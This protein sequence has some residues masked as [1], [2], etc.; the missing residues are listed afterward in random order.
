MKLLR[1]TLFVLSCA[2]LGTASANNPPE[3]NKNWMR[4]LDP[5]VRVRDISIPGTHDSGAM[6][7][8][9]NFSI[10]QSMTIPQQ[11]SAGIRYLD[12]R[13][14]HINNVFAIHHGE[15]YQQKMFGSVMADVTRFLDENPSEFVFMRVKEEYQPE[16]NTR[17]FEETFESYRKSYEKYIWRPTE[18][19]PKLSDVKGKIVF[20]QDFASNI[21]SPV[22]LE[23]RSFDVQDDWSLSYLTAVGKKVKLV[24]D[25]LEAARNKKTNVINN[26]A[27]SA[28]P[29]TPELL[30]VSINPR[31][32]DYLVSGPAQRYTGILPMD[33]P[34]DNLIGFLI[35]SNTVDCSTAYLDSKTWKLA[36]CRGAALTK[37]NSPA[38][39]RVK[40]AGNGVWDADTYTCYTNKTNTVR[41]IVFQLDSVCS[42]L[43]S[44]DG[45]YLRCTDNFAQTH[46]APEISCAG[47]YKRNTGQCVDAAT[48]QEKQLELTCYGNHFYVPEGSIKSLACAKPSASSASQTS[49][50]S[51]SSASSGGNL[52]VSNQVSASASASW[53]GSAGYPSFGTAVP[54]SAGATRR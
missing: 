16:G 48:S 35:N 14:R 49:A 43:D 41:P 2:L 20:I 22:G 11:L 33:F 32:Y 9:T 13:L 50:S 8:I 45:R 1:T 18:Q 51:A 44:V 5:Q 36:G 26:L 38:S 24:K 21:Y 4:W 39:F 40:C 28:P 54:A 37:S 10:N 27:V 15:V 7:G 17:S 6:Y 47:S 29:A 34:A 31:V 19:N 25:T 30:A 53:S 42:T 12:I 52:T 23:Y 3:Q 46:T